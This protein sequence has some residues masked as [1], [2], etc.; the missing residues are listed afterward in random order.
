MDRIL[1][2][3]L[4]G[5][6]IAGMGVSGTAFGNLILNPS[7]EDGTGQGTGFDADPAPEIDDWTYW[8]EDGWWTDEAAH[9]GTYSIK[10]WG[11]GLGMYQ[12]FAAIAGV[13][14]DFSLWA[15]DNSGEAMGAQSY[16]ELRVEW[17][18]GDPGDGGQQI[19]TGDS[20]GTF[21]GETATDTWTELS[22]SAMA[23]TDTQVGRFLAVTE[24]DGEWS[25]AV[26][27]DSASA[28]P[29]PGTFAMLLLGGLG[30]ALLR[31]R[32][33]L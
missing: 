4:A 19:G 27:F 5:L 21:Y 13:E 32:R 11:T 12:D 14:Y 20:I 17:W 29:E 3:L 2:R 8:G 9:D 18:D 1:K 28:I 31:H 10:R 7:F 6:V 24:D 33:K 15:Y 23:P 25:G 26:L 16:L 30:I 22:G